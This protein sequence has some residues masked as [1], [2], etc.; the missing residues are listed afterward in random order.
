MPFKSTKK[1]DADA[2]QVGVLV[3]SLDSDTR[4]V[5]DA[6]V[7][8]SWKLRNL[9]YHDKWSKKDIKSNIMLSVPKANL[10]S[11]Y[12]NTWQD[13]PLASSIGMPL[14]F[15]EVR[16]LEDDPQDENM[17]AN[18][19]SLNPYAKRQE[20]VEQSN[21]RIYGSILVVRSNGKALHLRDIHA[22]WDYVHTVLYAYA[23]DSEGKVTLLPRSDRK[24][25]KTLRK[26]NREERKLYEWASAH[27]KSDDKHVREARAFLD[28]STRA[29]KTMEERFRGNSFESWVR[30]PDDLFATIREIWVDE[31]INGKDFA[32][33]W[34]KWRDEEV[35][36]GFS[37]CNALVCPVEEDVNSECVIQ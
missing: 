3:T 24:K 18:I 11:T 13:A 15:R 27:Y 25:L 22:L 33:W 12:H 20:R 4:F 2:S 16:P 30:D 37:S 32:S 14:K 1:A 26:A 36:L 19:V 10:E 6:T 21:P 23:T 17:F 34:H 9:M 5:H 8:P 29:L 31:K 28:R 7:V 35:K